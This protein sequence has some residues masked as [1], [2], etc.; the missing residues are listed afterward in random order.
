MGETS[1]QRIIS[2]AGA[3]LLGLLTAG[4][5]GA[6]PTFTQQTGMECGGCH[7]AFPTLNAVGRQ[8]KKDGYRVGAPGERE[9][10]FVDLAARFLGRPVDNVN[11]GDPT[12]VDSMHEAEL[13]LTGQPA[14]EFSVFAEVEAEDEGDFALGLKKAVVGFHPGPEVNVQAGYAPLFFADPYDTLA[15]GGRRMT[16]DH[17]SILNTRRP[18]NR[19]RLRDSVQQVNVHGQAGPVW[20][21]VGVS[22]G[23]TSADSDQ[24][25][26]DPG[27]YHARVA[28]D[29]ARDTMV[30]GF[31]YAGTD[32]IGADEDDFTVYGADVRHDNAPTGVTVLAVVLW[33]EDD[34]TTATDEDVNGGYVELLR[35]FDVGGR[36]LVPLVRHDW[37]DADT[38]SIENGMRKTTVQ[39]SYYARDNVR[40]S[41]ELTNYNESAVTGDQRLILGFDVAF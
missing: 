5:A 17:K 10:R 9:A 20:Y 30:G 39:V 40:V 37:G 22:G 12:R 35:P 34:F 24:N 21:L 26:A 29:A 14:G 1:R 27:D 31:L 15:D 7:L 32:T 18:P 36:P 33:S 3:A 8:F 16:A 11:N 25:G 23:G 2:C 28:L 38:A 4:P 6:V 19:H 13:F 41:G